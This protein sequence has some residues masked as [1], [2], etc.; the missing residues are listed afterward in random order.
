MIM[1]NTTKYFGSTKSDLDH[2]FGN[3]AGIA[4]LW[5]RELMGLDPKDPD[6][7]YDFKREKRQ[8]MRGL[9]R[10]LTQR[11]PVYGGIEHSHL[12]EIIELATGDWSDAEIIDRLMK[13]YSELTGT[14]YVTLIK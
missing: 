1:P 6:E 10:T 12:E 8:F 9:R 7:T 3:H 14:D 13:R 5:H 2:Y 4:Y 11:L